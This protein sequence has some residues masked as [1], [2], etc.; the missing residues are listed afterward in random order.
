MEQVGNEGGG[1]WQICRAD[2]YLVAFFC[3][4][5]YMPM[6][7]VSTVLKMIV[8][9]MSNLEGLDFLCCSLY[10]FFLI[11]GLVISLLIRIREIWP[12]LEV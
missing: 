6:L 8:V 1:R 2:L 11:V 5:N 3:L 9:S 10:G 4:T 7:R 12:R